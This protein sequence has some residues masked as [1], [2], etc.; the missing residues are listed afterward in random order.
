MTPDT[1]PHILHSGATTKIRRRRV[2]TDLKA[3]GVHGEVT[4]KPSIAYDEI[5]EEKQARDYFRASA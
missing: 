1:P 2:V 4:T 3:K 5:N